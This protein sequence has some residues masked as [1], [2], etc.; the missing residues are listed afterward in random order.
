M[1]ILKI[2]RMGHP[3]L[4][5]KADKVENIPDPNVNSLV[6]DMI[7]TMLDFNGVGLAAPQIH[8]SKQIIIFRQPD[9]ELQKNVENNVEI[10]VLINPEI[11]KISEDTENNWEGCL[12][13][14]DMTGLVK[15]YSKIEYRGFD[16]NGNVIKK[17]AQGLHAR[18]VQ[19]EFDHL[20]G[21]LYISRL[22]DNRAYG[23]VDEIEKY[24][25]DKNEKN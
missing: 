5:K 21:I 6:Q 9:E 7:D 24:W 19:H 18:I 20:L 2:A 22:A 14:P 3:I 17:S 15:R 13:I 25:K 12:S 10:T 16:L 23:F 1:A 8:I 11:K 4:L